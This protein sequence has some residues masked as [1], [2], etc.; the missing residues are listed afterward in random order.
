MPCANVSVHVS[1]VN[2]PLLSL[3]PFLTA[4]INTIGI[5]RCVVTS[6]VCFVLQL[7]EPLLDGFAHVSAPTVTT[8]S[9]GAPI[10]TN[11]SH[12]ARASVNSGSSAVGSAT[13]SPA[14]YGSNQVGASCLWACTHR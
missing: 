3:C 12:F 9:S 8:T 7:K 11:G 2:P 10:V 6:P 13:L 1:A 5:R 4:A 14:G